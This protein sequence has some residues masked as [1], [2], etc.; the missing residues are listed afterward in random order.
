M[1]L[2]SIF[3]VSLFIGVTISV[4]DVPLLHW[5][6]YQHMT[7][8]KTSS[9]IVDGN[10][11]VDAIVSVNETFENLGL[12]QYKVIGCGLFYDTDV[13]QMRFFC[14]VVYEGTVN[15]TQYSVFVFRSEKAL[16]LERKTDRKP[17]WRNAD[18]PSFQN[19]V[20]IRTCPLRHG[21]KLF[22]KVVCERNEKPSLIAI[23]AVRKENT[24][25]WCFYGGIEWNKD[26][27]DMT[28]G[29]DYNVFLDKQ[30]KRVILFLGGK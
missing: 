29:G 5:Q 15:A 8:D 13:S 20:D 17:Y 18:A 11:L 30:M 26:A 28:L 9:F 10:F 23:Y 4:G 16:V 1:K 22:E 21:V 24:M 7:T 27:K 3:L 2:L 14:E 6:A 12:G 19:C 25:C